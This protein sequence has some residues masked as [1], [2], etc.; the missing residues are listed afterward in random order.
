M[1]HSIKNKIGGRI[2]ISGTHTLVVKGDPTLNVFA[3][4]NRIEQ[5]IINF[6]SNAVKF[7]PRSSEIQLW[8]EKIDSKVKFSVADQGIGIEEDKL[9]RLFN[10]F[11]RAE[12]SGQYSGMGLGLYIS[13]EII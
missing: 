13:S 3:D 6:I 5:I 11:Y 12:V 4:E 8:V 10:R 1:E 2:T 7:S 9:P